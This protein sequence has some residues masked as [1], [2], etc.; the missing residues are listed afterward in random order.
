MDVHALIARGQQHFKRLEYRKSLECFEAAE[1]HAPANPHV[2]FGIAWSYVGLGHHD[3]GIEA[4]KEALRL[5]PGWPPALVGLGEALTYAGEY[6]KALHWFGQARRR[7]ADAPPIYPGE[8]EALRRLGR[9]DDARGRV[10]DALNNGRCDAGLAA[11]YCDL[12]R[13]AGRYSE[14]MTAAK[15]VL[16]RDGLAAPQRIALLFALGRLLEAKGDY[17]AAFARFREANSL[18][19]PRLFS[20]EAHSRDIDAIIEAFSRDSLARLPRSPDRHE[21]LI[22][23]VGMPRSGTSL[24]EQILASHPGVHGAGELPHLLDIA[25]SLPDR[26][27]EATPY[28]RCIRAITPE[29]AREAADEYVSLL[30]GESRSFARVSDKMPHNF[31][32]VGLIGLLFPGARVVHCV[33]DAIDTCFSCYTTIMSPAHAYSTDLEDLGHVY[34]D[35]QRLMDH[36]ESVAVVPIARVR[37]EELVEAPEGTIGELL[38]RLGLPW[39]DRCLN[40]HTLNR[41]VLTPSADQV[42]KPIYRTSVGR[43]RRFERHVRPLIESLGV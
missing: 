7:V 36:W 2:K 11:E 13:S 22:F 43:W 24:V 40:H 38:D 9:E 8:V 5:R 30:P 19:P 34:R 35:Y 39:D 37:Y 20:R 33:R 41:P 12:C 31:L 42:H 15:A 23:I 26:V 14:G 27:G 3:R 32:H 16:E 6:E 10:R 4:Y 18:Y 28:P 1:A 25:R 21:R 29:A 17:E